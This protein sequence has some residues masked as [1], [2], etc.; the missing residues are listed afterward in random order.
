MIS[1]IICGYSEINQ[2][3]VIESIT[4]TIGYAHEILYYKNVP[5]KGICSIYNELSQRAKGD[6]ILFVHEDVIFETQNW[7]A[8]LI[9][10]HKNYDLLGIAG[11]K[12]KSHLPCS[13]SATPYKTYR[14]NQQYKYKT[15]EK[16]YLFKE[17]LPG[18]NTEDLVIIDGVFI[19]VKKEVLGKIS[20]DEEM[21][22][23]FH[24]YDYDF[25][26]QASNYFKLG[27]IKNILLTHKSDGKVDKAWMDAQIKICHKWQHKLPIY[28]SDIEIS[29]IKAKYYSIKQA[30]RFALKFNMIFKLFKTP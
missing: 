1:I 4:N 17:F 20:F 15:R 28:T 5:Q 11:A 25:C 9:N 21:L 26:L 2:V 18:R 6:I 12:Y 30:L 27:M 8:H 29:S 24:G 23:G 16:E 13:W 22:G 7:G 10:G 19:S 3:L 14:L